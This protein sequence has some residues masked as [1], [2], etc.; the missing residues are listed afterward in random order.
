MTIASIMLAAGHGTRMKSTLPKVLHPILGKPLVLHALSAVE[1]VV[2]IPPVV[3]IGHGAEDVKAAIQ[4]GVKQDVQFAIQEKQLG[5]GH[6]VMCAQSLLQ[7]K[8]EKVII[9]FA[10]MPLLTQASIEHIIQLQQESQSVMVITT[11]MSEEPPADL[12]ASF[13]I[14]T[15]PCR[16]LL[17]KSTARLSNF[18]SG[19]RIPAR[20]VWTPNGFGNPWKSY[21][22][23]PK[24][25]I[26]LLIWSPWRLPKDCG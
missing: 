10:D 13:A 11:V 25:S 16:Q 4:A 15:V 8:S 23:P 12:G 14:A 21:N 9:T 19:K 1:N 18:W 26:T 24:V 2:D 6:A 22:L 7:G 17:K 20:I 5:T 3:V